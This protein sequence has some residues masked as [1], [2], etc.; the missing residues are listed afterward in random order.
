MIII[1]EIELPFDI[2]EQAYVLPDAHYAAENPNR[3]PAQIWEDDTI[4][5]KIEALKAKNKFIQSHTYGFGLVVFYKHPAPGDRFKFGA[6]IFPSGTMRYTRIYA[7]SLPDIKNLFKKILYK[8]R[9]SHAEILPPD[10][11]LALLT[12]AY[13]L[14]NG[15]NSDSAITKNIVLKLQSGFKGQFK[16]TLE[17][18]I[19]GFGIKI[20][21]VPEF[22][23]DVTDLFEHI[24]KTYSGL[25][26][27]E[28]VISLLYIDTNVSFSDRL[29][30]ELDVITPDVELIFGDFCKMAFL[31]CIKFVQE[32]ILSMPKDAKFLF[33]IYGAVATIEKEYTTIQAMKSAG[34]NF[35]SA[36]ALQDVVKLRLSDIEKELKAAEGDTGTESSGTQEQ[37]ITDILLRLWSEEM[38][39]DVAGD[40][41]QVC[42][43]SMS[44]AIDAVK[45]SGDGLFIKIPRESYAKDNSHEKITVQD[46]NKRNLFEAFN[47]P[48][49]DY[50]LLSKYTNGGIADFVVEEQKQSHVK[51]NISKTAVRVFADSKIDSANM[52]TFKASFKQ[53]MLTDLDEEL[54]KWRSSSVDAL[55]GQFTFHTDF[56]DSA[57]SKKVVIDILVS[58]KLIADPSAEGGIP[59][60]IVIEENSY[61]VFEFMS[62]TDETLLSQPFKLLAESVSEVKVRKEKELADR[63][64][65]QIA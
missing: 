12:K 7:A 64:Q 41:S 14:S 3:K 24:Q 1:R 46:Q 30:P 63:D 53:L 43:N 6:V 65:A 2:Q 36:A 25:L 4:A 39:S 59:P 62:Q 50:P 61:K 15:R 17:S 13:G 58:E 44:S 5:S 11:L 20:K 8:Q 9:T 51:P 57:E 54:G 26:T 16:S 35:I 18:I 37:K 33:W 29:G 19:S 52:N 31:S 45:K 40:I 27:D 42:E 32:S 21:Y 28:M 10:E 60:E 38:F 47:I 56:L 34:I 49:S 48:L 22:T 55:E 23:K